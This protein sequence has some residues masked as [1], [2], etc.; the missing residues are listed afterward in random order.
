MHL[1][2]TLL[3]LKKI[4]MI[5]SPVQT[6]VALFYNPSVDTF[7]NNV[8]LSTITLTPLTQNFPNKYS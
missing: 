5:L 3:I 1:Y 8:L 2:S 7:N 6:N 4:D